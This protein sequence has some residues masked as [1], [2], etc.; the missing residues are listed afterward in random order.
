[1]SRL[2]STCSSLDSA[3]LETGLASLVVAMSRLDSTCSSLDSASLG[4][5]RYC[6]EEVAGQRHAAVFRRFI[7]ALTRGGPGGDCPIEML[8]VYL[9]TLS[10][11]PYR[12]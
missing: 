6:A 1:M 12:T 5:C 10:V 8:K 11:E 4:L 9:K 2:D 3:S 7:A